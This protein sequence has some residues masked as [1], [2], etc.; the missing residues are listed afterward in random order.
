MALF[1]LHFSVILLLETIRLMEEKYMKKI[2]L[3]LALVVT[4]VLGVLC[5]LMCREENVQ[6]EDREDIK[7]GYIRLKGTENNLF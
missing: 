5:F 3:C 2:V 4:V 6:D 7:R 1:L